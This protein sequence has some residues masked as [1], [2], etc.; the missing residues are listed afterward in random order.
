MELVHFLFLMTEDYHMQ[1]I[2][3]EDS[4]GLQ[5]LVVVKLMIA[6]VESFTKYLVSIY[7][8]RIDFK[9]NILGTCNFK[10]SFSNFGNSGIFG[11]LSSCTSTL[12]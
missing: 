6:K 2:F 4:V 12:F 3:S 9:I 7:K 10:T 11:Y 1:I 8:R 5:H